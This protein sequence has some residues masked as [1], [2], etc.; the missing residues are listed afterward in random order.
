MVWLPAPSVL[1]L[2]VAT[3]KVR[4]TFEASVVEVVKSVNVA[5]PV[6]LLT[7]LGRN[8]TSVGSSAETVAVKVNN[9]PKVDDGG[10]TVTVVVVLR[11]ELN[12]VPLTE[13]CSV[14]PLTLSEL[15]VTVMPA[16]RLPIDCGVNRTDTSQFVPG[17]SEV[18]EVQGFSSPVLAEKLRVY[19]GFVEKSRG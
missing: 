3:P 14:L 6:G 17:E 4:L 19:A 18:D 10:D 13:T 8:G 1:R 2:S 16:L 9:W 12:P 5:V 7:P 11:T 15:L